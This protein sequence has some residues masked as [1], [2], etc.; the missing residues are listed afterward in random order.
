MIIENLT[1]SAITQGN[2]VSP[3]TR[4]ENEACLKILLRSEK[5]INNEM[6]WDEMR[7]GNSSGHF[8]NNK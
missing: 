7:S 3:L 5:L 8:V 4:P 1:F 2:S 6:S